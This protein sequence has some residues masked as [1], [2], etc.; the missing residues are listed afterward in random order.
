MLRWQGGF[1]EVMADNTYSQDSKSNGDMKPREALS[2]R[3]RVE[4]LDWSKTSVG[5]MELWPQSLKAT[6]KTLLGSRYPMILLWG[7]ELVQIYNDAYT[8]LIG[9]KHP[10]ALG[11]SIK[12][13]QAESWDTI[14]PMIREVMTTGVPNWVPA[15]MLAVDRSGYDEETYFSLSYSAVEDDN[16]LIKGMLCVCS[17]VTQQIHGERRLRLQRDLAAR[18]GEIR[19][20]E[21]VC[22]DVVRALE[23]YPWDVPFALLYL[24]DTEKN[25][26]KL[27]GAVRIDPKA[28]SEGLTDPWQLQEAI[29]GVVVPIADVDKHIDLKGGP[30][31]MQVR[32]AL[33]LPIPSSQPNS[34][35]GVLVLGV[36]PSRALDESYRSFFELLAGQVSM[37]LRNAQAYEEEKKRAEALAEIDRAKTAFFNNISHEFRTP[38][39]LMLSPLEEVI[40]G[41]TTLAAADR[42]SIQMAYRNALRLLKLVNTLLDFSRIEAKRMEASFRP[43]DLALLS[44]E[45]ASAFR[46][47]IEK[48]GI[49]Y[50]VSC[51]RLS[52]DVSVDIDMWEKIVLN[53]LSNAFKFTFEGSINVSLEET[54][55][56]VLFTVADT[57]VGI[58]DQDLPQL[59]KR[60]HRVQ[61]TRSRSHEGTGIGLA[62]VKEL[63]ELHKGSIEVESTLGKGTLVRVV[64]PKGLHPVHS[65]PVEAAEERDTLRTRAFV[66][67]T[68]LW[69]REAQDSG[70]TYEQGSE[71]KGIVAQDKSIRLLLVDDN[72]DMLKYMKRILQDYWTVDTA[73]DG[74]EAL[75]Q[76]RQSLPSLVLSDVMMPRM[77]GFELMA[78][79]RKHND[80]RH[81]PVILLSARAGEEATIE[82]LKNG[83][84]DYLTKPFSA[85]ELVIRVNTQLEITHVKR[86]NRKIREAEE[87]LKKYKLLSDFAFDSL[88]LIRKDGS[89]A[90]LN[91]LA[92]QNWGYNREEAKHL[93]VPDIDPLF[94]DEKFREIFDLIQERGS[95][96]NIESVHKRKD[97]TIFP[98]EINTGSLILD[99]EPHIFS[100][101]RDITERKQA[102]ETLKSRNEQLLRINNDL[103]NFIYTASHDLK[104]PVSNIEGL[105]YALR[106]TLAQEE[107][108]ASKE[109]EALLRMMDTSIHRFKATILDLTEITKVQKE[110]KEDE[111]D[112]DL[113]EMIAD[114]I[115]SIEDKVKEAGAHIEVDVSGANILKFSKKNLKSILYNLLS[116]AIKYKS[117]KRVPQLYIKAVQAQEYLVLTV[118]DNGLGI[119]KD[120]LPKMFHMFKRFHDH[121]EGTGI[122]LYIVKRIL[123]NAGG[124]IEVESEENKGTLFRVYFRV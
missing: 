59:F 99:G 40:S 67:E 110:E 50:E 28:F 98:V 16:G 85:R 53:L 75:D 11:R 100:I 72:A 104:A 70:H 97:G 12:V 30:W 62:F 43:T 15:Q 111:R 17:E 39:T 29:Q 123:D 25:I 103:D 76:V 41:S 102:E 38:L 86:D 20:L 121:V 27:E 106:D 44:S 65:S 35:L 71:S 82:G 7:E 34:P 4:A 37:A 80:T 60:F 114:V 77:N 120:S 8:G 49:R 93:R 78:E 84:N 90:Y 6:I 32:Q 21:M 22:K 18:A 96:S 51:K 112:I 52:Q 109:A 1:Y 58:A 57:G 95:M 83:A 24:Q 9:D 56:Q 64:L 68:L 5:P 33:S 119:S 116:N 115:L 14:G 23:D 124:K 63:V 79:L 117:P 73:R 89:F 61:N 26:L 92:L 48:E 88:I 46:S 91:D 66:N 81:V 55:T 108:Q 3:D 69:S 101:S 113:S 74:L 42:E 36:N 47:A 31:H 19:S 45:L 122:G 54:E 87:E 10:G 13:T 105:L 94:P 107:T 2:M 118:Q